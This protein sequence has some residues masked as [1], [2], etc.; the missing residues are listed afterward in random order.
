MG[1]TIQVALP[2]GPTCVHACT[3]GLLLPVSAPTPLAHCPCL[4]LH[5][6]CWPS[7]LAARTWHGMLHM[8]P[9]STSFITHDLPTA[10]AAFMIMPMFTSSLLTARTWCGVLHIIPHAPCEHKL[11]RV[12]LTHGM[13]RGTMTIDRLT[14]HVC[15]RAN[16]HRFTSHCLNLAWHAPNAPHEH[17]L[18]CTRLAHDVCEVLRPDQLCVPPLCLPPSPCRRQRLGTGMQ[19]GVV[20]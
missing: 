17:E 12:R 19:S 5:P 7:V 8:H 9:V 16:V 18:H 11:H 3:A 4:C 15:D 10:C 6:H 14:P 1:P 20:L 2:H 13:C